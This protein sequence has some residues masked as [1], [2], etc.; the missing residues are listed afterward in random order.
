MSN[1]DWNSMNEEEFDTML[2]NYVSE[3][4][5]EDMVATITP[6]K[7]AMKRILIGI[8]LETI[9]LNFL[10]LNF[11]LPAIGM[12]LAFLGFRSLRKENNWFKSGFLIT[13]VHTGC[14]FLI[15]MIDTTIFSGRFNTHPIGIVLRLGVWILKLAQ[16]LC[17]WRGSVNIPH[18]VN[19]IPQ[20][21]GAGFLFLW[22]AL[23]YLLH[24]QQVSGFIVA[25]LILSFFF[26]LRSLYRFAENL[27]NVGYAIRTASIKVSDRVVALFLVAT[28]LI[29]CTC[30]HLLL[31]RYLMDWTSVDHTTGVETQEIDTQLLELGFPEYVLKDLTDEEILACKSASKVVVYTHWHGTADDGELLL[32]SLGVELPGQQ[33]QWMM[34]HHFLWET[35]PVF[36]GTEAIQLWTP[37]V[38]SHQRQPADAATGRVLYDKAGETFASPYHSLRNEP[39]PS[40][41]IPQGQEPAALFA[42]FSL[43]SE[44]THHRGYIFYPLTE[45]VE[46]ESLHSRLHYIH[47]ESRMHYPNITA[48]EQ[49]SWAASP[50]FSTYQAESQLS[51]K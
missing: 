3:L 39:H 24:F 29:G 49:N 43:P 6:W 23:L 18:R 31:G 51:A 11:I 1:Q 32:T 25:A 36:Y 10:Y 26:V 47:Q 33:P 42:T 9:V 5:P 50:I 40:A 17:L 30:G 27:D 4:P 20:P 45:Q 21:F 12:I 35:A 13:A 46:N 19:L 44:G 41:S 14:C 8:A 15:L 38:N 7:K 2:S 37:W 28:L 22:Y 48:I 34:I 16:I